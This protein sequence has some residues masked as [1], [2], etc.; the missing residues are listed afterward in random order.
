MK[1]IK[2]N[3]IDYILIV[4]FVSVIF[5]VGLKTFENDS[6]VGEQR[7][8]LS[9]YC[10]EVPDFAAELIKIGD[11]VSDEGKNISLGNVLSINLSDGVSYMEDENEKLKRIAKEGYS[12]VLLK[13]SSDGVPFEHGVKIEGNRYSVGH[14]VVVYAGKAKISGKISN[15]EE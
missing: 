12:S 3:I 15:I 11:K 2:L 1:K 6:G 5:F 4:A 10:E 13:I 7:Y 14:S 8:V 9:V